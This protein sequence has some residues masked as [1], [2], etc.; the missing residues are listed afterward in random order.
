VGFTCESASIAAL[1]IARKC[2]FMCPFI[3]VE[4]LDYVSNAVVYNGEVKGWEF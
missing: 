3:D 2:C 1:T 4:I